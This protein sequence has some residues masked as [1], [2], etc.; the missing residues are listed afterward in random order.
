MK[1]VLRGK[2]TAQKEIGERAYVSTLTEHLKPLEL[3]EANA[4]KKSR[5][6]EIVLNSGLKSTK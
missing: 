2:L 3:K 4:P 1:A 5:R 6:Q